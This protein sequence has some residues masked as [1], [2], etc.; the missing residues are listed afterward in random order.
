MAS[1]DDTKQSDPKG[2][3]NDMEALEQSDWLSI[4][5]FLPMN[6]LNKFSRIC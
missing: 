2:V 5:L 1:F 3:S 4:L 6:L